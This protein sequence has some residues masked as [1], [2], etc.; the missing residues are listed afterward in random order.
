MSSDD[1]LLDAEER[2]DKTVRVF[3]ESLR[4]IGAGTANPGLVESVRVT[5]YG[6]Q[7]PLKQLAR[8]GAPDPQFIVIKPYDPTIVEDIV[9]AIQASDIGINPQTDGKVIRLTV[10]GLSEER[11]KQLAARVKDMAEEGRVAIRNIRRDAN[12]GLE[13]LKKDSTISEDECRSA[14][15]DVQELTTQYEGQVD[16]LLDRKITDIVKV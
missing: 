5:Y 16:E 3:G 7:T 14:R 12:K 11:R 15:D 10:P 9:K 2:M 13:R 1:L 6:S 8:I 4:G